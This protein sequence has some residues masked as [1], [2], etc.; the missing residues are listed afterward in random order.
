M[1][2]P[3]L[4]TETS[5]SSVKNQRKEGGVGEGETF[6]RSPPIRHSSLLVMDHNCLYFHTTLH[7]RI[8]MARTV[9]GN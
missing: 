8:G 4:S 3:Q 5:S 9:T 7:K 6:E 1:A 2:T